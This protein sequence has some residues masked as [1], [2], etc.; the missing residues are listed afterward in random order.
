MPCAVVATSHMWLSTFNV[1]SV[2][3]EFFN[4]I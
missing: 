2:T 3:E 1:I 4:F